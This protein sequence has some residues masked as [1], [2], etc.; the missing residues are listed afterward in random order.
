MIKAMLIVVATSGIGNYSVE[1]P[2]MGECLD[3]RAVIATQD[4]SIK[5]L[6]VPKENDTDKFNQFFSLFL[7]VVREIKK[8]ESNE[9]TD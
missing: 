2:T 1:M 6:C 5:T 8:M 9:I 4:A 3:A 7:D